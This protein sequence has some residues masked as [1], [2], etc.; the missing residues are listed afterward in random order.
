MRFATGTPAH[1]ATEARKIR[2]SKNSGQG[3]VGRYDRSGFVH[4]DNRGYKADW[5]G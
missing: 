1:W 4:V 2:T 3:G 5:T